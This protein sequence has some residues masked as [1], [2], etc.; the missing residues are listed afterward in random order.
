[1]SLLMPA[2]FQT[3]RRQ[4]DAVSKY[5][6]Y[7]LQGPMDGVLEPMPVWNLL[8]GATIPWYFREISTPPFKTAAAI[9]TE[10]YTE[11]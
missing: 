5:R 7:R 11:Q 3:Q 8:S 1:M 9:Q 10:I 6:G 4:G 2:G